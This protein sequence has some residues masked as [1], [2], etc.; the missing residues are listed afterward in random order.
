MYCWEKLLLGQFIGRRHHMRSGVD[1]ATTNVVARLNLVPS[2]VVMPYNGAIATLSG[3]N[4][5][6]LT[7]KDGRLVTAKGAVPAAVHQY[8]RAPEVRD[9]LY[10]T[11]GGPTRGKA[12]DK[13]KDSNFRKKMRTAFGLQGP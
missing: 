8:D 10:A 12:G 5:G 1:P 4:S 3:R 13:A 2:S 7:V 6:L 11:Y 9:F